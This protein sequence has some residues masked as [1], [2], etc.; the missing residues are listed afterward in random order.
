MYAFHVF[1]TGGLIEKPP[2]L[3]KTWE[4]HIYTTQ[5]LHEVQE[6]AFSRSLTRFSSF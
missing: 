3:R 2:V 4:L 5:C 1:N 6:Y